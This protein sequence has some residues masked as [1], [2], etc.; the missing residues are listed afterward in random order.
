LFYIP[1][2]FPTSTPN[3]NA[4]NNSG[5][6]VSPVSVVVL[7]NRQILANDLFFQNLPLPG[8]NSCEFLVTI[9]LNA[10]YLFYFT[11]S[12]SQLSP[13]H[14]TKIENSHY[15]QLLPEMTGKSPGPGKISCFLFN[16]QFTLNTSL[17]RLANLILLKFTLSF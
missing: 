9:T 1:A 16:S 6:C 2:P 7:E 5:T 14:Q 11:A 8:K 12:F 4:K 15:S 17:F 3:P 13:V 10:L